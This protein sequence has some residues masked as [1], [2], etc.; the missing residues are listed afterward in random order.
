M[1]CAVIVREMTLEE[2]CDLGVHGSVFMPVYSERKEREVRKK[3]R[4]EGGKQIK[5]SAIG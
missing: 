4:K 1:K 5:I 2:D 3:G